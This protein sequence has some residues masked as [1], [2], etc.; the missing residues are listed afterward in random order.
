MRLS[1]RGLLGHTTSVLVAAGAA[2]RAEPAAAARLASSRHSAD[3]DSEVLG[4]GTFRYRAQRFWGRLDRRQYPVK[5]CHGIKEDRSGR[6]V[7]LT[8]DTHNNLIAYTKAG[9]LRA[10]WETRFP[11]AHGLEITEY[12]GEERFWITDWERSV[13]SVCT[14]DGKQ[15]RFTGPEAVKAKYPDLTQ[16]HPTNTAILPDGD[17]YVS[18]GYGSSFVHH[19]DPDGRY[20]SSFGGTGNAPENLNT[21]HSVWLDNRSGQPRLLVCDRNNNKLKYFSLKGELQ[22]V[23]SLGEPPTNDIPGPQPCN[24]AQ[25]P[26]SHR[27]E[28]HIAVA[29]LSS[30]ILILDGEDRVVSAVGG[31]PPQY[32]NGALQPLEPFNYTFCHPHDVYVD[33]A[34]ALYVAQWWSG[35][36]Y[37]IKLE[38][39]PASSPSAAASPAGPVPV[40]PPYGSHPL[41]QSGGVSG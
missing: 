16:Y 35:Q 26:D 32:V 36:S 40:E 14:A 21:P 3:P 2:L 7:L 8:D 28:N 1:R 25:F 4:Q 22:R 18:D 39:M 41:I 5:N 30:M 15:L 38:L 13:V 19:F 27:L 33:S 23:V 29:C 6:I 17:F 37:P 20:I 10:A 12:R 24:V 31:T 34:G 11:G 9:K